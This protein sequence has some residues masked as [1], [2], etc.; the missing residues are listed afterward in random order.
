MLEQLRVAPDLL[1]QQRP[2]LRPELETLPAV[3]PIEV[4]EYRTRVLTCSLLR[5]LAPDRTSLEVVRLV[6][7]LV[8]REEVVHD[9]KVDLAP[10]RELHAV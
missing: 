3:D 5:V 7:V 1:R 10:V 2:L 6:D 9:H 4:L 8:R